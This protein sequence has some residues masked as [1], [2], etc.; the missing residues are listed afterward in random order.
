[1]AAAGKCLAVFGALQFWS[2]GEHGHPR[3]DT[4]WHVFFANDQLATRFIEEIDF[5]YCAL[6][7]TAFLMTP[8]V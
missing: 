7:A 2:F 6:D 4:S 1:M 8:V 5:D 3:I